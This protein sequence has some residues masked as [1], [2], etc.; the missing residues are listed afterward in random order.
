[1]DPALA[2]LLDHNLL[3][4]AMAEALAHGAR[5]DARLER[6]RLAR[7]AQLLVAR[8]LGINHSAVLILILLSLCVAAPSY[9]SSFV[10]RNPGRAFRQS[11]H[12]PPSGI[13]PASGYVTGMS[14]SPGPRAAQ[15]V[16]HLTCLVPNP[17]LPISM[18]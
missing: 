17:I 14:C 4:A 13:G 16:S 15:H 12:R 7:N 8:G 1:P 10:F 6:Q 9:R 3:A 5:F 18:R 11:R 2:A